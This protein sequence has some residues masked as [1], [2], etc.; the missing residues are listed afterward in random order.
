MA[1]LNLSPSTQGLLTRLYEDPQESRN[2]GEV[3]AFYLR[4]RAIESNISVQDVKVL[5][6][7]HKT[8]Y[9]PKN[10]KRSILNP[11]P[12]VIIVVY[13]TDMRELNK[14]KRGCKYILV[15]VDAFSRYVTALSVKH[16]DEKS[17]VIAM[18]SVGR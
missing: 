18:K 8:N 5:E 11:K 3:R 2:K 10:F 16:K 15:C 9:N 17:V 4:G 14:F 1:K 12:Q 6:L 7:I 13:L